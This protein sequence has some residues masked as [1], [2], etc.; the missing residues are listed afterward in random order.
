FTVTQGKKG[1]Q[2][3]NITIVTNA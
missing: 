1:P 3:S 2:A